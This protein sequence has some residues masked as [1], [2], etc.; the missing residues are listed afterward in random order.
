M[1][2]ILRYKVRGKLHLWRKGYVSN[3]EWER[4]YIYIVGAPKFHIS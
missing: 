2:V 1:V 4:E 3:K